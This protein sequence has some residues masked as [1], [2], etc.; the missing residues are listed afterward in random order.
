MHRGY[1][2][3]RD[4]K[5]SVSDTRLHHGL[6]NSEFTPSGQKPKIWDVDQ[7]GKPPSGASEANDRLGRKTR[8]LIRSTP[9]TE[10][11]RLPYKSKGTAPGLFLK[12]G[13]KLT[14]IN[15]IIQCPTG[16]QSPASK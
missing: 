3:E 4:I 1:T 11:L 15:V 2:I 14:R 6:H 16:A 7:F 13:R 12:P 10:H 5:P 9:T 8:G